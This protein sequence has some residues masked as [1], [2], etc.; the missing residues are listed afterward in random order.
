[1]GIQSRLGKS[2]YLLAIEVGILSKRGTGA[3]EGEH[4]QGNGDWYIHANLEKAEHETQQ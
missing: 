2:T 3:S 4:G 1:M